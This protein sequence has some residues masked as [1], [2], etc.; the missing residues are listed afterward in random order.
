MLIRCIR[1]F[2]TSYNPEISGGLDM[3]ICIYT[4]VY[5]VVG[6]CIRIYIFVRIRIQI[7]KREHTYVH[8]TPVYWYICI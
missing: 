8:C 4:C 1:I 5:V 2:E 3:C 7:H 6:A